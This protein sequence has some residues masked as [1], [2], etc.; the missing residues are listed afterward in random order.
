MDR[1]KISEEIG[2]RLRKVYGPRSRRRDDPGDVLINTVLSQN[3]SDNNS[4][5]AFARLKDR[6]TTMREVASA[7]LRD[8][9]NAIKVGG[10]YRR[11]A[12]I[13][14][15]LARELLKGVPLEEMG[16]SEARE[17]LRS[18]DGVGPKTA[19][20]VLLFG[21]G[22][23]VL[24]VDTHVYRLSRRIGLIKGD[25]PIEKADAELEKFVPPAIR[26]QFHLDLIEHGRRVCRP[27]KPRCDL[28]VIADLC[29]YRGSRSE[30]VGDD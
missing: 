12:R 18:L 26:Y 24:P 2:R 9:E 15:N 21:L 25:L 13:I 22:R 29:Q 16:D 1:S 6:F 4:H 27:A 28:C 5:R 17:Y 8:I 20:C 14:R 23:D 3:T 7:E 10:L 19:S 30:G 11:K